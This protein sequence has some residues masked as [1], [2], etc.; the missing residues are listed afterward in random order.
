MILNSLKVYMLFENSNFAQLG[1]YDELLRRTTNDASGV[2]ITVSNL[3]QYRYILIA[4]ILVSNNRIYDT[5]IIPTALFKTQI[6]N[7][8]YPLDTSEFSY[9]A[10]ISDTQI[11]VRNAGSSHGTVVY[12][13]K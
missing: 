7:Q 10:Y 12:G 2:A 4:G 3:T 13:I 5:V 11:N 1:K 9:V 6:I 8:I